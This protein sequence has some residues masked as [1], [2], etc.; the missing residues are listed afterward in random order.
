MGSVLVFCAFPNPEI[1]SR[2]VERTPTQPHNPISEFFFLYSSV[3]KYSVCVV[4]R[5]L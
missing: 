3:G 2:K 4:V 1:E 5:M